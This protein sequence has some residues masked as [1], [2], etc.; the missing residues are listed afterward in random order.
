[1]AST[2][3]DHCHG[4]PVG[5]T[6]DEWRAMRPDKRE[7]SLL[8]SLLLS[9]LAAGCAAPVLPTPTLV[10]PGPPSASGRC[11][12][13]RGVALQI[14]GS[15]GPIP[16]SGRASAGYL[17]WSDGR[18]RVL[19]DAG[20]G[21]FVRFGQSGAAL[22][23]LDAILLTHL[24]TDHSAELPAFIKGMYFLDAPREAPVTLAGPAGRGAFPGIDAWTSLMIGEQGAYRYLSWA[25][26]PG[27]GN[28]ALS[29]RPLPIEGG[30]TRVIDGKGLR[31]DAVGVRHGPVPAV[32][33]RVEING[34][35]VVFSGDQNGDNPA[36]VALA[37]DADI[38]VMHHAVPEEA[39]EVASSLHA[40][41]SE[42][43]SVA[44]RAAARRLVLSHHMKRSLNDLAGAQRI[45][46]ARYGGPVVIG[47]D[48][49]CVAL[50][51]T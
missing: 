35:S 6:G 46:A 31:V 40:R 3:A 42:I 10:T 16:D 23:T 32:A 41:P 5:P 50:S 13:E 29:V 2:P 19:V 30:S 28:V 45:I 21:T 48:L 34:V 24:H 4:L 14:L 25:L 17:I 1:M 39:D 18:A 43:G 47:E 38:L 7:R 15:G 8:L 44:A 33:Y 20:G 12:P 37:R 22:Q 49:M 27:R 26:T 11:A 9:L 36:F 51:G